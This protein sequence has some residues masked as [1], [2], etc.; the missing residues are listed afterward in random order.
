MLRAKP[1]ILVQLEP[2]HM[3]ELIRRFGTLQRTFVPRAAGGAAAPVAALV[4][5]DD[6][7]FDPSQQLDHWVHRCIGT[8]TELEDFEQHGGAVLLAYPDGSMRVIRIGS[9]LDGM[10]L[11]ERPLEPPPILRADYRR[12]RRGWRPWL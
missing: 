4:A 8:V 12:R 1:S 10:S 7:Y 11:S 3:E 5:D 9:R 6:V 2:P